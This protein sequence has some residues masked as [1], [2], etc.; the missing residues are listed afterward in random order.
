MAR[1]A[2]LVDGETHAEGARQLEERLRAGGGDVARVGE[3]PG[4]TDVDDVKPEDF[5]AALIPGG[6]RHHHLL[7]HERFLSFLRDVYAGGKT[8][9]VVH[10]DRWMVVPAGLMRVTWPSVKREVIVEPRGSPYADAFGVLALKSGPSSDV[11]GL[12]QALAV[13]PGAA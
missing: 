8:I 6:F 2:L 9:G 11:E 3:G 12:I 1:F 7:T 10:A 5:D 4:A 13:T